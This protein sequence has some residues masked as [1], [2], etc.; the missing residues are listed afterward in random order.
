MASPGAATSTDIDHGTR[1][2]WGRPDD[3]YVRWLMPGCA[4]PYRH[5]AARPFQVCRR[6][7]VVSDDLEAAAAVEQA[8]GRAADRLQGA[9]KNLR[10]R[11]E[12]H[13]LEIEGEAT[14][15]IVARIFVHLYR[16]IESM[17]LLLA[18]PF[19][20]EQAGQLLRG[21][22][23]ATLVLLWVT[24]PEAAVDRQRRAVRYWKDGIRQTREKFEYAENVGSPQSAEAWAELARQEAVIAEQEAALGGGKLKRPP[25]TRGMAENLGQVDLYRL[26]RWESDPAHA[27]SVSLGQ[28]VRHMTDEHH[29]LGGP[30]QPW[31]RA[32]RFGAALLV[33]RVAGP[34]ILAALGLS[35]AGWDEE[36]AASEGQIE[37]LLKPYMPT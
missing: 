22:I 18:L 37:E 15:Q 19:Y 9:I 1:R 27:S 20:A 11:I 4:T 6:F 17:C 34:P 7:G 36:M 2:V 30:N 24:E 33:L 32:K 5:G 23:D 3:I 21:A 29:E 28:T 35:D 13:R 25:D 26:W 31:A 14:P 8:M 10:A 16:Q 12:G